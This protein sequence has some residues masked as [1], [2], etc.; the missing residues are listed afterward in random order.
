MDDDRIER[1]LIGVARRYAPPLAPP[2]WKQPGDYRGPLA[3]L[4]RGLAGYGALVT[5]IEA[6]AGQSGLI[7]PLWTDSLTALYACLCGAL[8]PSAATVQAFYADAGEPPILLLH[9]SSIPVIMV[10]S[11]YALPYLAAQHGAEAA[12]GEMISLFDAALDWLEAGDLPPSD[13]ARL[14]SD[15]VDLLRPL[16]DSPARPRALAPAAPEA[17]V[18]VRKKAAPAS[19]PEAK[20]QGSPPPMT[21]PEARTTPRPAPVNL[22]ESGPPRPPLPLVFE[23]PARPARRRPPLPE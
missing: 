20:P 12:E 19:L 7:A 15:A 17:P 18:P 1:A 23:P 9:G 6:P 14:R 13:F 22:P 5:V 21:L 8:F 2:G 10:L 4:A 16:L 11:S 3:E